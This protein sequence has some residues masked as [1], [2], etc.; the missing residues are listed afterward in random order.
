M[1]SFT[2]FTPD[3]S[4]IIATSSALQRKKAA[5]EDA[6][7]KAKTVATTNQATTVV[8]QQHA[9]DLEAQA[10]VGANMQKA[11][12]LHTQFFN[13]QRQAANNQAN[14]NNQRQDDALKRRFAAIGQ[15]GSG[16]MIGAQQQGA[17]GIEAQREA[18]LNSINGQDAQSLL[19]NNAQQQKFSSEQDQQAKDN[20]FRA[21]QFQMA[22]E[23]FAL[24][25]DTNA[26][27]RRI[28]ELQLSAQ[29]DAEKRKKIAG[30]G[31]MLG[32]GVGFAAGGPG[33]AAVGSQVGS[34]WGDS[35]GGFL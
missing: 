26:F 18:S 31:S 34:V 5:E 23:Q 11:N 15:T 33:G 8:D 20:A 25:K 2:N 10:A 14:V 16:A 28:A 19:Q 22:K 32:A 12:D 4:L 17:Q 21:E 24:D 7:V 29:Q 27:N 3:M 30:F 35:M 13:T 6:Q 9:K 1:S